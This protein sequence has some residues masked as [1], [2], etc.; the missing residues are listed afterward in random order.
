MKKLSKG[1]YLRQILR[2]PVK[3]G[4]VDVFSQGCQT[5]LSKSKKIIE[6]LFELVF[7]KPIESPVS[8]RITFS[9][10]V[11]L[12]QKNVDQIGSFYQN[13]NPE[14]ITNL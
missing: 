5:V 9:G 3:I 6:N 8:I 13:F 14:K 12:I 7:L 10:P 2:F 1:I 11:T 4:Q